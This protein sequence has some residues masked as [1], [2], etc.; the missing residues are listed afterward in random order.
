M[1]N[2]LITYTAC[3]AL[4]FGTPYLNLAW[5]ADH[6]LELLTGA[7]IL[8][9]SLS[10]TLYA[11]SFRGGAVLAATGT[12]GMFTYDFWMGRELNPRVFW[13][14]LKEFCELYPGLGGWMLLNLAFAHK[15]FVTT[16][17]VW[18]SLQTRPARDV[19]SGASK[20]AVPTM[21]CACE[22]ACKCTQKLCRVLLISPLSRAASDMAACSVPSGKTLGSYG[23]HA[24]CH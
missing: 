18:C 9:T 5:C 15:Q 16:G 8:A 13:V 2:F 19:F 1:Q 10:L 24:R 14:D 6:F 4:A 12:S 20:L 3:A 17:Q 23:R 11:A 7:L 21:S 22:C